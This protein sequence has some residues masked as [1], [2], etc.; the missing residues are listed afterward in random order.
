MD[1][2]REQQ[3]ISAAQRG[4]E[5]AFGELYDSCIDKVYRY[6]LYRVRDPEA[7]NDLTGEVFLRVVEGLPVYQDRNTP[8]MAWIYRIAHA[9]LVD[10]YRKEQ[11]SQQDQDIETIQEIYTDSEDSLDEA[12]MD[13]HEHQQVRQAIQSLTHEQQQ[14]IHLRF[15]E[16][17]NVEETARV[18][19]K[20]IGA[21]KVMQHRA[22]QSLS[23]IL[24]RKNALYNK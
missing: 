10:Y 19:K 14:L 11:R 8:I 5:Q 18:L 2:K 1:L 24:N 12:L 13:S 15:V 17:Y 7:A 23:R 22:I 16:G 4:D 20:T 6:M 9:R 3:L 21:V